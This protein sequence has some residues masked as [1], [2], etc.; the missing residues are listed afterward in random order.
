[1]R[2]YSAISRQPSVIGRR[3]RYLRCRQPSAFSL[4]YSKVRLTH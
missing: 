1:M 4:F 2:K 3:P